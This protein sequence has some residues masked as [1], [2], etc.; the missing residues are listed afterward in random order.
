MIKYDFIKLIKEREV[1]IVA[2]QLDVSVGTIRR[3]LE[4]NKIPNNQYLDLCRIFNLD[5]NYKSLSEKDKDQFFTNH[6]TSKYCYDL[7]LLK[8]KEWG[9]D[10]KKYNFIE[11]SAGD[12]SFYNLLP[13]NKRIGIDIEPKS[14]GIIQGDFLCWNPE[15]NTNITIGNPPFGTRG[16]TALK[17]INHAAQFSDFVCFILPQTFD[18][19]GKGSCKKRV[20]GLNLVHNEIVNSSFY[21]PSGKTVS[22]NV[23]FQ[24]WAKHIY[25]PQDYRTCD[26]YIKVYSL[27]DGGTSGTTRNLNKI[28]KCD[29]Y[30]PITCFG[31]DCMKLY[32]DFESLPNRR[33]FGIMITKDKIK[34]SNILK[35]TKWL[36]V[37]FK[38]TNGAFNLR[39]DLIKRVL[40]ENDIIDDSWFK[41]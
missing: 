36:N 24:I 8:L 27:S 4:L 40:I 12:G 7:T 25:I 19:D 31:E 22:V 3:W 39:T 6:T 1:S 5:V 20:S 30:L 23:V 2:S 34:V 38:S 28:D 9:I 18:S 17:F 35:K 26:S 16:S 33:G 37:S 41:Y 21:Y 15:D 13:K 32:S 29:L 10:I 14:N 11:P